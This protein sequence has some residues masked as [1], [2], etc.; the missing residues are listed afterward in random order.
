MLTTRR[1]NETTDYA[2]YSARGGVT[3]LERR[4][5]FREEETTESTPESRRR[6]LLNLLNYD[7]PEKLEEVASSRTEAVETVAE[8]AQA[9]ALNDEDIRPSSTTMQ[10]G[11][12]KTDQILNDLKRSREEEKTSYKLNGKGKLVVVLY[13]L[14]VTVILA[15]IVLN[16]GVLTALAGNVSS[17]SAELADKTQAVAAQRTEIERISSADYVS[18]IAENDYGMELR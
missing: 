9:P 17:L 10:F 5:A 15:L 14:V 11:E 1:Q 12:G 16:T 8:V 13:A 2:D 7:N 18:D 3:L 6:N 4:A